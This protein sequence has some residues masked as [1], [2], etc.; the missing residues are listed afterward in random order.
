LSEKPSEKFFRSDSTAQRDRFG[1]SADFYM[2]A[3]ALIAAAAMGLL[4]F[5]PAPEIAVAPAEEYLEALE[6]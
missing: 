5:R 2:A 4:V 6:P 3:T 1:Y